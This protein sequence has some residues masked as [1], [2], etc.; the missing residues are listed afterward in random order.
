[1]T[2]QVAPTAI[3]RLI[4]RRCQVLRQRH[5]NRPFVQKSY[6]L[7]N[8][9]AC[10]GGTNLTLNSEVYSEAASSIRCLIDNR[11]HPTIAIL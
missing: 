4:A 7:E 6:A 2:V 1:M 5:R 3:E 11:A 9:A 8:V 10:F